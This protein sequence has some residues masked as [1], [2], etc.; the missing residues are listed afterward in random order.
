MNVTQ[1]GGVSIVEAP[2]A[3]KSAVGDQ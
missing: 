2:D 3:S 1:E